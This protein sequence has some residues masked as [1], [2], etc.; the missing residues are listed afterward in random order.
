MEKWLKNSHEI[1]CENS[2]RIVYMVQPSFDWNFECVYMHV[3]RCILLQ[4]TNHWLISEQK[5]GGCMVPELL[6]SVVI[7][8]NYFPSSVYGSILRLVHLWSWHN[9]SSSTSNTDTATTE[10]VPVYLLIRAG[11]LPRRRPFTSDL[12][13]QI[14]NEHTP[15]HA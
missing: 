7:G 1:L 12:I 2:C 4:M 15:A 13:G 8:T 5:S 6:N 11:N 9:Y 14:V 3:S 10:L